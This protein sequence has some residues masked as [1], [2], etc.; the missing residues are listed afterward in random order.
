M[1]RLVTC[2]ISP[3]T[4]SQKLIWYLANILRIGLNFSHHCSL[5]ILCLRRS[6]HEWASSVNDLG[7]NQKRTP[8]TQN[9]SSPLVRWRGWMRWLSCWSPARR[10]CQTSWQ[11]R[12]LEGWK[13]RIWDS[14]VICAPC[15]AGGFTTQ[16]YL[17]GN[18]RSISV[19]A[20]GWP[21]PPAWC[22]NSCQRAKGRLPG[23]KRLAYKS[24]SRQQSLLDVSRWFSTCCRCPNTLYLQS[25]MPFPSDEYSL[26][27][28][29]VV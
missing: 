16:L 1:E 6:K 18:F 23:G 22:Q 24:V 25:K 10:P 12:D 17:A 29:S 15:S 27:I 11:T 8:L 5:G 3:G 9:L 26:W 13:R 28:K 20:T 19:I 14:A 2:S 21:W 4:Y 7:L